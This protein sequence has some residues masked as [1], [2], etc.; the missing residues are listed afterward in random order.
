MKLH[1][2]T[3]GKPKL[4]FI[5]PGVDLYLKRLAAYG[6][7]EWITVKSG[8]PQ[9]EGKLLLRSSTSG[10][11]VVLDERGKM[12]RSQEL[13]KRI[14]GWEFA[15]FREIHFLIGG[16]DG[17]SDEVKAAAD[18]HWSLS[19]L[20]L[21]HEVALLVMMEQLY[22]AQTIRAGQPYHRE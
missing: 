22:R 3:V 16:A 21:Q 4:K 20:T 12:I 15:A 1:I 10:I 8:S 11:R 13:A 19:P 7:S 14:T 17:H 5:S 18:W 2:I 9:S 6:E